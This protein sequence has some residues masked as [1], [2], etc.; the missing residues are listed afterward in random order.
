MK[1]ARWIPSLLLLLA[2]PTGGLRSQEPG[3]PDSQRGER[4]LTA[5]H[6]HHKEMVRLAGTWSARVRVYAEPDT[7]PIES[8]GRARNQLILGGAS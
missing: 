6:R 3:Q 8:T 5:P 2:V 1:A 7:E 4:P